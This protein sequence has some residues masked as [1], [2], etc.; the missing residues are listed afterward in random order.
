[1]RPL[2]SFKTK[3]KQH[4]LLSLQQSPQPKSHSSS[5]FYLIA[6]SWVMLTTQCLRRVG[7]SQTMAGSSSLWAS[8]SHHPVYICPK[9]CMLMTKANLPDT[10]RPLFLLGIY[11]WLNSSS[12]IHKLPAQRL[13]LLYQFSHLGRIHFADIRWTSVSSV[14]LPLHIMASVNGIK[15]LLHSVKNIFLFLSSV[16]A[17]RNMQ[18]KIYRNSTSRKNILSAVLHLISKFFFKHFSMFPV[19][20]FISLLPHHQ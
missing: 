11:M 5:C 10:W 17:Y 7:L 19:N 18:K 4:F 6:I 3:H 12:R 2:T 20:S 13:S 14:D 16:L 8:S 9:R 15:C 1:M